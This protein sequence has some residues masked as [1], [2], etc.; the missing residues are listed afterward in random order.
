M[1]VCG[2]D[3][4]L[5]PVLNTLHPEATSTSNSFLLNWRLEG[6]LDGEGWKTLRRHDSDRGLKGNDRYQTSTWAVDGNSSA[7]RYFRIFQTEKNSSGNFGIFLS[8]IE[9]YGVLIEMGSQC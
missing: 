1:V 4:E 9:L 2:P 7:F 5:Y 6:S 3:R 8:G